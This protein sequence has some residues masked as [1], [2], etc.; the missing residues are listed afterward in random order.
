MK[1]INT[2]EDRVICS[3]S[4]SPLKEWTNRNLRRKTT[5]KRKR[6]SQNQLEILAAEF[7]ICNEWDKEK[8]SSLSKKTGLSEGQIYKWS[9]DQKKKIQIH[10]KLKTQKT[11]QLSE[12]FD[13]LPELQLQF[14]NKENFI[15]SFQK[16]NCLE[17][18][19]PRV[20]DFDFYSIQK[21]YRHCFETLCQ[22]KN[23]EDKCLN[24]LLKNFQN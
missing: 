7:E 1:Y 15:G 5:K 17:I 13:A 10:F 14:Q 23:A 20:I 22:I 4:F 18:I 2:S 12:I 8:I 24:N 6:K 16:L 3:H 9:W 21:R 19:T 11:I